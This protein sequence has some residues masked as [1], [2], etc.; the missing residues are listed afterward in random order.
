[1]EF[2][3]KILLNFE[4][5]L[6]S[7]KSKEAGIKALYK[8]SHWFPLR[9]SP[10]LAGIVADLMGDGHL[11]DSPKLRLD[12]TSKSAEELNRFG[13]EVYNIFSVK[14]KIRKCS[15][16]H[17]GTLNLGINCKPLVR[18]LKLVGVPTGSKVL[19]NF[20][21]PKWVLENQILFS[22]F[23]DRLFSCEGSVD[24]KSRCIDI[25][26][27]KSETLIEDGLKFFK[28]IKHYLDIYFGIKTTEPFS[29]NT[30]NLRK[31]GIR[32]RPI[33]LKIKNI[34]S[35]IKFRDFV[36]IGD[37]TKMERLKVITERHLNEMFILR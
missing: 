10:N 16:N 34:N 12:Y 35:L 36:G 20:T 21:I 2:E 37:S 25:K 14:G 33:R 4:D 30:F 23:I 19:T 3:N 6:N 7:Y 29:G 22:R 24:L 27:Y 15:T 31:D 26:M 13:T 11:Q 17:Y 9:A 32:T 5:V 28:E 8:Y 18:V 1:M